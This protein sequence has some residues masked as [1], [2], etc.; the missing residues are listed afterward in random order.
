VPSTDGDLDHLTTDQW[1][2]LQDCAS[3]LEQRFLSGE[4]AAVDLR[5]FLPPAEA[6]HR[7]TVLHELIKT[8]LEARYRHRQ[9][10]LLEEFLR[11][12][13]E[14]GGPADL[15]A[16]LLYE[17]YRVRRRFGDR[18]ALDEYR[19]RFPLQFEQLRRRLHLE[20][21][22]E[23][24]LQ[25]VPTI[26]Y[27]HSP[28]G[29]GSHGPPSGAG[30]SDPTHPTAGEPTAHGAG[31]AAGLVLA[32]GQG[33]RKLEKL[34]SGQFG[35]VWR[36]LAP[37]GVEV[38]IKVILR[39]LDH[40]AS[41][42]ELKA[43]EKIRTLHHVFLLQIHQYQ[44]ERDHLVIV[45]ELADGSLSDRFKECQAKG[46]PGIPVGELVTYFSQ[47]AE[48]LDYLHSKHVAHRDVKPENLLM[49]GGHAKVADFGLAREQTLVV[50]Q[51]SVVAGTPHY[52]APEAWKLQ[53]SRHG[54]QYSLAAAYVEMRLGRH[55]FPGKIPLMIANQHLTAEP[56]LEPLPA[57]E[58]AVLK[59]ALAKEPNQR[60]PSCV[61]FAQALREA[62]GPAK[63]AP[64]QGWGAKVAVA[65]LAFAL[66]AVLIALSAVLWRPQ[67]PEPPKVVVSW[68]PRGWEPED[69]TDTVEDR[70][71]RQYYRRLVREVGAQKVVVV[72]V[73]QV[74]PEDPP[75]FYITENKVWND[76]YAAF[77][78]DPKSDE[79][80]RKYSSRPGCGVL[81]RN[82]WR[83]GGWAPNRNPDPNQE[84]FL[85]VDGDRGRLPVFRVT[86]TEAH[87][88]AEWLDGRLPSRRQWRKAAG[89]GEDPR[90]GPFDGDP[91]DAMGLAINR[92][93]GPWPVDRGARDVSIYGCR[94]MASNGREWTRDLD[95]KVSV[96]P[97][98]G[99]LGRRS[100]YQQGQSYL[101]QKPLTFQAM[102]DPRVGDCTE[103]SFE[104]TFRIVL[105]QP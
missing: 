91:G 13:P 79:L 62:T 6:P 48:A 104:V 10:C 44:A 77:M 43:L 22:P 58:Q 31:E 83:K 3:R 23:S 61:A 27:N 49:L 72:A 52:M 51:T 98:E 5:H 100:A 84:P 66:V 102:S 101:S 7:L 15:P 40:E 29:L 50:D 55:L 1:R 35:E 17:E 37:G 88:F 9:G 95:D 34:G 65:S 73:R 2:D 71:G 87:C 53:V 54:D 20:P 92:T 94:Q 93:D 90:P 8:E 63:A 75:T 103:P 19:A 86:V 24:T 11:R 45:M 42:K 64:A 25:P 30:P 78:S 38:A 97:L 46:L 16:G 41:R 105:E 56:Q 68:Q 36:A 69:R 67:P 96:I 70:N 59:R 80:L 81:V 39:T 99:M 21:V 14:L 47:A 18:P 28:V 82:E 85:G 89:E 32:A 12:Y 33:Y 74:T 57:A 4:T 60:F 76:L 26:D